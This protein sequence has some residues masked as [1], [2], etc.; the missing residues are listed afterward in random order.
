MRLALSFLGIFVTKNQILP[1]FTQIFGTLSGKYIKA[2]NNLKVVSKSL[3]T[4]KTNAVPLFLNFCPIFFYKQLFA[5]IFVSDW[6]H[7]TLTF[8]S[9]I[10]CHNSLTNP[11]FNKRATALIIY[12]YKDLETVFRMFL[13]FILLP[14][15]VPKEGRFFIFFG[16]FGKKFGQV[17]SIW[18]E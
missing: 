4:Y 11:K 3:K 1:K 12:V 16:I 15:S 13:A 14:E 7:V 6:K 2:R 5:T 9:H 8:Y 17:A 18:V 10:L